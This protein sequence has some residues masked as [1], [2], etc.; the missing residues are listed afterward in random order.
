MA[1]EAEFHTQDEW[2]QCYP[3]L[4]SILQPNKSGMLMRVFSCGICVM[5]SSARRFSHVYGLSQVSPNINP[6]SSSPVQCRTRWSFLLKKMEHICL[7]MNKI[8][9][10]SFLETENSS[11]FQEYQHASRLKYILLNRHF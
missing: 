6:K 5:P 9:S 8:R 10:H 11:R 7:Y 4:H 2:K 1:E 3:A